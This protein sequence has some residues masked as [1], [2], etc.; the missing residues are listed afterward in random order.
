MEIPEQGQLIQIRNRPFVV[1]DVSRHSHGGSS[2]HMVLLECLDDVAMG[3]RI[4]VIWEHEPNSQ[5]IDTSFLPEPKSWDQPECFDAFLDAIRWSLSSQVEGPRLQAA[6]RGAI[7]LDEYQLV[8]V[9]RAL[10]MHRVSLLL[11]DDVGLGKTIEAALVMLE[12]MARRRVRRC[13]IVC[14]ASL[15]IQWKE[16][17]RDKFHMRFDIIDA[18]AVHGLRREYGIHVN[19]WNSFPRL[20]TSMDFIKQK[21]HLNSFRDSL[22]RHGSGMSLRN[23]DLLIV[24]EAHNCTPAASIDSRD[25]DRARMLYEVASH[26]EH[27]LFLTATP[28]NGYRESFTGLLEMLDPLRFSRGPD[29]DKQAR[30]LVC[31]RRLKDSITDDLGRRKFARLHVEGLQVGSTATEQQM[32]DALDCYCTSR[33][34]K[35]AGDENVFAVQFALTML[36]KRFLSSPYSFWRSLQTHTRVANNETLDR[37]PAL[38]RRLQQGAADDHDDD[39]DKARQEDLALEESSRFFDGLTPNETKTLNCL[40]KAAE[41]AAQEA[42]S[43]ALKLIEW[44]EQ[45]LL[46]DSGN[47]TTERLI[48]FT[49]YRDTLN[50]LADLFEKRGWQDYITQLTGGMSAQQRETIKNAFQT[51]PSQA[52]PHRILLATDAA[53]EGLNLQ[54][55][56]RNVIHYEIP[57][58]PVRMAQRNGRVHRHGQPAQDVYALHFSYDNNADQRFLQVIVEKVQRQEEDLGAVGEVISQQV[59]EAILGLRDRI[60]EPASRVRTHDQDTP[61]SEW[62]PDEAGKMRQRLLA[63]RQQMGLTPETMAR[64]IDQALRIAG[65]PGLEPITAGELAHRAWDWVELPDTWAECGQYLYDASRSHRLRL[66]FDPDVAAGRRDVALI[67]LGHPLARRAIGLFRGKLWQQFGASPAVNRCSYR[68]LPHAALDRLAVVVFAR[69]VAVSGFSE[70]LHESV[71]RIGAWVSGGSLTVMDQALLDG[72]LKADGDFPPIPASLG[73][74]LRRLYP[75]HRNALMSMLGGLESSETERVGELLSEMAEQEA[76]RTR[77]HLDERIEEVRKR[78]K[79]SIKRRERAQLV[80]FDPDEDAR[81]QSSIR[82]LEQRLEQLRQDRRERPGEVKQRFELKQLRVFPIGLLYLIPRSLVDAREG[83]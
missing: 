78:L 41:E 53:S 39:E 77:Q 74:D 21:N 17:M 56:C 63:A 2:V 43:K 48:I 52:N 24:D 18:A 50:Y 75:E 11:A 44:I 6:F 72:I 80:L 40:S 26:F 68:V 25:S 29:L 9:D 76:G 57:W 49:E 73:A 51:A 61:A 15:Q 13:L 35:A 28:H 45:K 83:R 23:W 22:P 66:V 16:E 65:K 59:Q 38:T 55:H 36:K 30:D 64:L 69:V 32:C 12:L 70:M 19:P 81:Y 33:M 31:I 8:P 20:I 62:N 79:D 5:V 58:N 82:F 27:K 47:W 14:P 10:Q 34:N 4:R 60:E 67:H 1:E 42:D 37:D 71:L 7:E 46:D 54:K 3:D